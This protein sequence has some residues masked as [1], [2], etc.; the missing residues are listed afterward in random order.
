MY[1]IPTVDFFGHKISRLIVGGN[2]FG[3]HS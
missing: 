3:G 2:P 1:M